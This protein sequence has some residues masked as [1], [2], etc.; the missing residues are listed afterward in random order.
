[1]TEQMQKEFDEWFYGSYGGFS[2]RSEYFHSECEVENVETRRNL[3][4]D[5]VKTAF[6]VGFESGYDQGC[7]EATGGQ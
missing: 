4:L 5:W 1:M 6:E 3:L 7:Y 2:C